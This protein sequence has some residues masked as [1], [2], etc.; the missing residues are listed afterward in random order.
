MKQWRGD[1]NVQKNDE[2]TDVICIDNGVILFSIYGN[3]Y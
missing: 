3:V 2:E 1:S